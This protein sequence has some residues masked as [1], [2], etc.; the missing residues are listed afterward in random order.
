MRYLFQYLRSREH[1]RHLLSRLLPGVRRASFLLLRRGTSIEAHTFQE[2]APELSLVQLA[3]PRFLILLFH[4]I[5]VD[6]FCN[7]VGVCA[8]VRLDISPHAP[9]PPPLPLTLRSFLQVPSLCLCS[10]CSCFS[11]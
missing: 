10:R 3:F 7:V 5:L 1:D 8:R 2:A 11:C 4:L 9:S 6:G